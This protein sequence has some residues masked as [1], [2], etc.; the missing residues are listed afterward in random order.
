MLQRYMGGDWIQQQGSGDEINHNQQPKYNQTIT[1]AASDF[2]IHLPGKGENIYYMPKKS[3]AMLH[4]NL[5][6][7]MGQDFLDMK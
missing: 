2:N 4:G 5:L 6:N 3:W 1:T 7:K